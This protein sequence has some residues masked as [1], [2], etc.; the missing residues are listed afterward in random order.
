MARQHARKNV[1][2]NRK[3]NPQKPTK[4]KGRSRKTADQVRYEK[5]AASEIS[6][7]FAAE[8]RAHRK[9]M[10]RDKKRSPAKVKTE[11]AENAPWWEEML[12]EGGKSLLKIAPA[13][14]SGF[15]DYTIKSNSVMAHATEGEIGGDVPVMMNGK[16]DCQVVRHR[17][18]IMDIIGSTTSFLPQEIALNPGLFETFPWLAQ[19][20]N[21]YQRYRWRGLVFEVVTESADYSATTALG[22]VALSTQYN[23]LLPNFA[24][25]RTMLN[26]EY[27]NSRKP[28]E[29]F[30]HPIECDPAKLTAT[31]LFVRQGQPPANADLR[32]YDYG[33]TTLAVGGNPNSTG[34]LGELWASYEIEF[35]QPILNSDLGAPLG[36]L[37]TTGAGVAATSPLGSVLGSIPNFPLPQVNSTLGTKIVSGTQFMLPSPGNYFVALCWAGGSAA[38]VPPTFTY[39]GCSS[40]N[41]STNATGTGACMVVVMWITATLANATVTLST[42]ASYPTSPILSMNVAVMPDVEYYVQPLAAIEE[43]YDLNMLEGMVRNPKVARLLRKLMELEEETSDSEDDYPTPEEIASPK[44]TAVR[45]QGKVLARRAKGLRTGT[46]PDSEEFSETNLRAMFMGGEKSRQR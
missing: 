32:L 23:P 15:G 14:I 6:R 28:S 46:T 22:Y 27:A 30:I 19:I 10:G 29:Q 37:F 17:E 39:V 3:P 36:D 9:L 41:L 12:V 16:G 7:A 24:D 21:A 26:T 35:Y 20:A 43:H 8:A 2:K 31:E 45:G 5:Q 38:C 44:L 42:G 18:Y 34:I 11:N 13:V 4:G 33:V 25:K 40:N 1:R